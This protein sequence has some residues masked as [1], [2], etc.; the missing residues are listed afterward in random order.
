MCNTNNGAAANPNAN[1][2][3]HN[4]QLRFRRCA[5]RNTPTANTP[6][7][8][9][10][11]NNAAPNA[12]PDRNAVPAAPAN[13]AAVTNP[14][15]AGTLGSN[16]DCNPSPNPATNKHPATN[17]ADNAHSPDGNLPCSNNTKS[18]TV[19]V[20]TTN[21]PDHTL[22]R[23]PPPP[24]NTN[25]IPTNAHNTDTPTRPTV[26]RSNVEPEPTRCA[27]SNTP[28]DAASNANTAAAQ[29]APSRYGG[30]SSPTRV[31]KASGRSGVTGRVSQAVSA[32]AA[33]HNTNAPA[34]APGSVPSTNNCRGVANTLSE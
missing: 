7:K 19:T 21:P 5:R 8:P 29:G 20:N 32:N 30:R 1:P 23:R 31:S 17:A 2:S 25:P 22:R 10:T 33:A 3:T 9:A 26:N 28:N 15:S 11:A 16:L 4:T 12:A 34:P 24:A 14:A 27:N 6:N 18:T 13:A